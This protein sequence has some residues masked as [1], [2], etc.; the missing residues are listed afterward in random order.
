[1]GSF[2][3]D[4]SEL[5]APSVPSDADRFAAAAQTIPPPFA[6]QKH[7][8]DFILE[9]KRVLIFNDPGT[10]K[11]R[12]VL[13]AIARLRAAGAGPALVLAPKA[14]LEPAWAADAAKFQPGLTISV[15]Y[16]RNR[17]A[18]MTA[19]ADI[20]VT[21]HDAAD[22]L[23]ENQKLLAG[24]SML[25]LDESTAF[26]NRSAIRSRSVKSIAKLFEYRVAMTGTPM[27]NGVLDVW[28]QALLVD[29]GERLGR[30]F[31]AFRNVVCEPVQ[32]GLSPHA[33]DWIEKEGATDAVA[34]QLSDICLRYRFEDCIDIPENQVSTVPFTLSDKLRKQYDKLKREAVLELEAGEITAI[35]A[36]AKLAKL[37][38]VCSGAV[39]DGDGEYHV[40]DKSRYEL[41]VELIAQRSSP[42][43]V[44]FNWRHQ[45]K[46]LAKALDANGITYAVIDGETKSKDVPVIVDRFQQGLIRALLAHPQSASHGLT[47]T[48]GATAIWSSPTYDAERFEQ[49]NR[50]IYRAGQKQKSETILIQA[51]DTLEESVYARLQGKLARQMDLLGLLQSL[52]KEAT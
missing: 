14:I 45:K 18:A 33:V 17:K 4:V 11:T 28:H 25:V 8:T 43:L 5:N 10:G 12:S 48:R 37:L 27:P 26:K 35:N 7:T 9:K 41:I 49:F 30:S 51:A 21:N 42:C 29:D 3:T 19:Q 23:D 13:D 31:F 32:V 22:W 39:Y 20:Y 15:A 44:A 52:T 16:A 36:A 1:M 34:D 24:F 2:A 47:L 46:E 50:R 38:Q 6:H 40:L